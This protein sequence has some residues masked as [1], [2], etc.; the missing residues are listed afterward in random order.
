MR[1]KLKNPTGVF[2]V[3]VQGGSPAADAGLVHGDVIHRLDRTE[4][5]SVEELADAVKALEPGDYMIEVERSGKTL[6]MTLT[7]E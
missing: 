4:V 6:F 7:I 3:A 2:V 1:L 5:T